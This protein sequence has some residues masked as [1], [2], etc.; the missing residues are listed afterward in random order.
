[1]TKKWLG[2]D[3]SLSTVSL[4]KVIRFTAKKGSL[5]VFKAVVN[6]FSPDSSNPK[7]VFE[8]L[9][10]AKVDFVIDFIEKFVRKILPLYLSMEIRKK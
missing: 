3:K 1:M 7:D 2:G 4:N 9:D 8:T 5:A 6:K 10:L